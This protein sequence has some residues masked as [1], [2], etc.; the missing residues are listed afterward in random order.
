MNVVT[1]GNTLLDVNLVLSKA[2]VGDRKKIAHLGCGSSGHFVFP[3]AK[4]VGKHGMV[5]AV[6]ILKTVLERIDRQIKQD[7]YTNTVT[8]WSDL[9]VFGATRIEN[10]SLD[11]AFLVN[12]LF[13]SRK[14]AE[15]MREAIRM[16]RK[17]GKLVVVEWKNIASPFGPPAE[18]RVRQDLLEAAGKKLGLHL[19]EE[20][21]AGPFHYGLLFS[22]A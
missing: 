17:N 8:I 12:V 20:F 18:E 1:G 13:E 16:I 19:E 4:M 21:E 3:S 14:R 5:Y 2:Q 15:I 22:K 6:D 7:N 11:A 9:E 10:S